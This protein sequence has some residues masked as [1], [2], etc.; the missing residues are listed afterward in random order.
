MAHV[1]ASERRPQLVRAAID[2]MGREG[3]AA[4]STR[5][6]A[7]ELGVAQAT[8]HYTFGTKE[9]LYRA[10]LEQVTLDLIE[11]VRQAVPADG[12]FEQTLG[13]LAAAQWRT[14]REQP[15]H[16]QLL[17]ELLLYAVRTPALSDAPRSH[18]GEIV[19]V[20]ADLIGEAAQRTGRTLAQSPALLARFY[21]AG[22]EGLVAQ[23]VALPDEASE[24]AG[25]RNLVAALLA[26]ADGRL[27][28]AQPA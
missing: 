28:P 7:T 10:V 1:P 4:G 27:D 19:E 13:A 11:R 2:L 24:Q 22:F 15:N 14:V 3:I 23:H 8:V 12:T 9:G 18:Y 26:L 5:A 21:L 17:T 20:T 25:L 6:I 16:Y